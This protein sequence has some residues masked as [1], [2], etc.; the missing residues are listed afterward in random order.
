MRPQDTSVC[1]LKLLV[2]HLLVKLNYIYFFEHSR[3]LLKIPIIK[4]TAPA[5]L[6][7][8]LLIR[9]ATVLKATNTQS[10][11]TLELETAANNHALH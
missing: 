2:K 5:K 8:K 1:G 10:H 9:K 6:L 3:Q 7:I 4:S 11:F